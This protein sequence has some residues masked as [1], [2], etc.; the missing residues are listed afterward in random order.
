MTK[1]VW[2][3]VLG[4]NTVAPVMVAQAFV[5]NIAKSQEKRLVFMS[6]DLGSLANTT[7][8]EYL[9]RSSKAALNMVVATL[10]RD[11]A[12]QGIRTVAMSPGWVRTGMGGSHASLSAEESVRGMKAVLGKL[13]RDSTG[14]YLKYD[15]SFL[16]W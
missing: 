13:A 1:E 9:Y 6:S 11:L 14:V 15:G 7:G 3:E 4:V 10:A 8:G 2:L 12:P 5:D 16:S